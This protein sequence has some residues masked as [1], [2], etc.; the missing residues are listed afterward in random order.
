MRPSNNLKKKTPSVTYWRVQLVCKKV[1]T[2]S[3]LEPLD[4]SRFAMT[5]F[6]I[7]GVREILYSFRLALEGK[8]G[9]EILESGSVLG[10]PMF[11]I[12][13]NNLSD[14][15]ASNSK[16]FADVTSLFSVVKKVGASNIHLNND[17]KK[18]G[19]WEFQWKMNFDPYPAKQAQKLIFSC[20][21]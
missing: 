8:T 3:S 15:L 17:F 1:Q 18:I 6:T 20:Q 5:F 4:K 21:V 9:K 7:L 12:Y 13:I 16:L 19:E 10:P 11:L 2:H 14:N